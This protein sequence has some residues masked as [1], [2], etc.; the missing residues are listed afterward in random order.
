MH[1]HNIILCEEHFGKVLTSKCETAA[2]VSA[3]GLQGLP[4]TRSFLSALQLIAAH[5]GTPF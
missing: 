2:V 5:F 4:L 1:F 3:L